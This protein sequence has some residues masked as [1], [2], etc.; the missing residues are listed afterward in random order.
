MTTDAVLLASLHVGQEAA[1]EVL[2]RRY[3]QRIWGSLYRLVG[4]EA[5]DLVQEVFMRL[6]RRP[7]KAQGTDL[8]AWLYRVATNLGYNALR[9]RRRR[10]GYRDLLGKVTAG[11]GW[12]RAEPEPETWAMQTEE[13]RQ[14]RIGLACLHERQ[15]ALLVLRYSGL[16]Y[17]EIA[18][19]LGVSP[20][21]VGT[22]LARA[23]RAF[24][25]AYRRLAEGRKG[26]GGGE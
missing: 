1:F 7:P 17:R 10:R 24:E 5:E 22:L 3:Y 11:A 8:G 14:V 12:R 18:D 13:Q 21:S 15:A 23:E 19:V 6:Y 9:A 25:G 2:F 20:A 16:S 4:D 26:S